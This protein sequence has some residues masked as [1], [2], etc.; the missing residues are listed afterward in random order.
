MKTRNAQNAAREREG[1]GSRLGDAEIPRFTRNDGGGGEA[2]KISVAEIPR[3][4]ERLGMTAFFARNDDGGGEAHKI[5]G[6]RDSSA[7]RTPRNDG[8]SCSE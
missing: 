7:M 8:I 4:C 6:C 3:L 1:G 5:F 2:H